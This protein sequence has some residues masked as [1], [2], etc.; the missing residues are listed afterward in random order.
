ML[1]IA[2]ATYDDAV[3]VNLFL[4]DIDRYFTSA[5]RIYKLAFGRSRPALTVAQTKVNFLLKVEMDLVAS[6]GA[7]LRSGPKRRREDRESGCSA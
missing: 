7:N 5:I 2:G 1:E 6:V 4:A 3:K